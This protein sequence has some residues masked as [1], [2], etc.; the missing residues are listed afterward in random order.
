MKKAGCQ[1]PATQKGFSTV[2]KLNSFYHISTHR[3]IAAI[4]NFLPP[5]DLIW[6]LKI[7]DQVHEF[8]KISRWWWVIGKC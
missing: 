5:M 3:R 7:V 4:M 6:E 8:M 2:L 1:R